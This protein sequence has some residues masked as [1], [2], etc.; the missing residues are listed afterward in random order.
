[1][2]AKGFHRIHRRNLI[3]NGIIPILIDSDVYEQAL[4]GRE[5][6]LPKIRSEIEGGSDTFTLQVEDG[7]FTVRN[8]LNDPER[9]Q[10]LAGGL[11]R[12]LKGKAASGN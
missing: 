11:L 1:V 3:N 8:D 9:E 4:L 7:S 6:H 12:H 10:L 5:W 2:F